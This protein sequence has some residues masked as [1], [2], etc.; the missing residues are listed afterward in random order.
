[1]GKVIDWLKFIALHAP[2]W[3]AKHLLT[4]C[5][6]LHRRCGPLPPPTCVWL[7]C[8]FWSSSACLPLHH[9]LCLCSV[10]WL[11]CRHR[12]GSSRRFRQ[13][14]SQADA[15]RRQEQQPYLQIY[16][17]WWQ[18]L[19]LTLISIFLSCKFDKRKG[20]ARPKRA[21]VISWFFCYEFVRFLFYLI[22][23][24]LE[25]YVFW[26][27]QETIRFIFLSVSCRNGPV[28]KQS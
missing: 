24:F 16:G 26:V 14:Q 21:V 3:V 28:L 11:C 2:A 5:L 8:K 19:F 7:C 15:K 20:F 23:L 1:M 17:I 10:C 4:L 25:V 18:Q 6:G 12:L 22:F 27:T 9:C 13:V